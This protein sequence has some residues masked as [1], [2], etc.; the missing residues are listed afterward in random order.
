M[1]TR[2]LLE[3]DVPIAIGM[4][5]PPPAV[6]GVFC[7]G[8]QGGLKLISKTVT[9]SKIIAMTA[10]AL[11]EEVRKLSAVERILFV[12]YILDSLRE[13]AGEAELSEE[14][15]EELNRR[16]ASYLNGTAKT[17][18]WEEVRNKVLQQ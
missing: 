18:T 10:L 7:G 8:A 12:Q 11:K 14:W 1:S 2:H 3:T 6:A 5:L 4:A 17:F 16:T 9:L 13:D 15:K